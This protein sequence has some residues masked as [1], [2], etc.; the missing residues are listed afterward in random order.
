MSFVA[1]TSYDALTVLNLAVCR[2]PVILKPG[3]N[4]CS[5]WV[6]DGSVD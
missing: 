6:P 1:E 3:E 5:L 2:M 4:A